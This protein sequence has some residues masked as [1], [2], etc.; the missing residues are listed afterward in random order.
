LKSGYEQTYEMIR[1]KLQDCDFPGAAERLGFTLISD[2]SM[3]IDFLGRRFG[4][5]P[6]GVQAL[7]GKEA[8]PNFLS[9]LVYYAISHGDAKPGED[10]ALLHY[11]VRALQSG[12]S[13]VSRWMSAPLRRKFGD[14]YQL[15]CQ[16]AGRLGLVYEG[17][18][19]NGEHLWHYQLLPKIPLRLVYYEADEEFPADIQIYYDKTVSLFLEFEP[20]AVLTG[21][22]VHTLAEYIDEI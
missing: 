16:A 4:I 13:T 10:F 3:N 17:S 9:V 21:C 18:W 11:F 14:N 20:L 7:D 22:F 19:K 15:F 1:S 12:N 2:T 8:D 6:E 5:S